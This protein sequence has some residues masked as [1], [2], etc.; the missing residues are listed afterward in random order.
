MWLVQDEFSG[1]VITF[2]SIKISMQSKCKKYPIHHWYLSW[3]DTRKNEI[4]KVIEKQQK[5][6]YIVR[7][8]FLSGSKGQLHYARC[9]F[10]LFLSRR[11]FV[12]LPSITVNVD[13]KNIF[14]GV[15]CT[16]WFVSKLLHL[17]NA[18][19]PLCSLQC[20]FISR[21]LQELFDYYYSI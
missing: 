18:T 2:V 16:L 13:M 20:S 6:K 19:F 12:I 7:Q 11:W 4:L 17:T 10:F 9:V 5:R 14:V 21:F 3:R 15:H 8:H 1:Q